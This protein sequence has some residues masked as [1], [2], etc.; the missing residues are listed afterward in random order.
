[1]DYIDS[2]GNLIARANGPRGKKLVAY[3]R[4]NT[5]RWM[6]RF[7]DDPKIESGWGHVYFCSKCGTFLT[8]DLENPHQH[9][10]SCCV[11]VMTGPEYDASW[12]YLYRYDALMSAVQAAALYRISE[13]NKYLEYFK[14]VIG[15]YAEKLYRFCEH[16]RN[17]WP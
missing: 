4:E 1:M 2:L 6:E 17:T 16:G 8:F 10:C 14:K 5:A 15:F 11:Q 9:R 12:V 13:E 7:E 3:L